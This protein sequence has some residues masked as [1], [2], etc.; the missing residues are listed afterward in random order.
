MSVIKTSKK[1]DKVLA[2][3][4]YIDY[5]LHFQKNINKIQILLDLGSEVNAIM[6]AYVFK[7]SLQIRFT[8]VK[9]QKINGSTFKTFKIVLTSF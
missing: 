2:R 9:A 7:L 5:P 1:N 6:P 4:L 8:N 3:I